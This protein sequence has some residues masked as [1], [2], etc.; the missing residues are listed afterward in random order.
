MGLKKLVECDGQCI[1]VPFEW[2]DYMLF[3]FRLVLFL[4]LLIIVW[5]AITISRFLGWLANHPALQP[6]DRRGK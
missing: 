6:F 4:A 5:V 3:P 2:N 1:Q